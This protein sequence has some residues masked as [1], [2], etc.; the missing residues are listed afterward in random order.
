MYET[1]KD[2]FIVIPTV[3]ALEHIKVAAILDELKELDLFKSFYNFAIPK[4][5]SLKLYDKEMRR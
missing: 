5:D 2:N 3:C 4:R 1:N